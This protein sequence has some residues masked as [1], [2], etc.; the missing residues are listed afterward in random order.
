M[1]NSLSYSPTN[2]M[3][4]HLIAS[5]TGIGGRGHPVG[6]ANIVFS[7]MQSDTCPSTTLIDC[8]HVVQQNVE[9]GTQ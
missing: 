2:R 9:I 3:T 7:N 4:I 8:D 6:R 5:A 1:A